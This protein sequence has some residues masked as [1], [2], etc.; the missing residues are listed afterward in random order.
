M[1]GACPQ[2]DT[3]S[4]FHFPCLSKHFSVISSG[5]QGVWRGCVA[6][7][8]G[9]KYWG[10]ETEPHREVQGESPYSSFGSEREMC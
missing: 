3:G 4:P 10:G 6:L 8:L 7:F 9:M 5:A 2:Q 1:D